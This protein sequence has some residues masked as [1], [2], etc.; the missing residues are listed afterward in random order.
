MNDYKSDISN[1]I[2]PTWV[3][4]KIREVKEIKAGELIVICQ[5][6]I[7]MGLHFV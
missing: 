6:F 7:L 2:S 5:L 3:N 1:K 4:N